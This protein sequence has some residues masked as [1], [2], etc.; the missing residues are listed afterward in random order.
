MLALMFL[1][2]YLGCSDRKLMEHLNG[3]ISFQLFCDLLLGG[4]RLTNFKIISHIRTYLSTR[5]DIET[6]QLILARSWKPYI[7]HPGVML[8]DATCYET[9]M[10]Y[11]T[12]VKNCYGKVWTGVMGS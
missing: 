8:T 9:S 3:N 4:K 5:L 10:R 12:N 2:S 11:P 1:K 7:N 6:A